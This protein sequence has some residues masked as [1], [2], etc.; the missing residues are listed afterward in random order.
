MVA[1]GVCDRSCRASRLFS[2]HD[3]QSHNRALHRIAGVGKRSGCLAAARATGTAVPGTA[4]RTSGVIAHRPSN[5]T[6]PFPV[7]RDV[8]HLIADRN[9]ISTPIFGLR[10]LSE[11]LRATQP[12]A[13]RPRNESC[14]ILARLALGLPS[15]PRLPEPAGWRRWHPAGGIVHGSSGSGRGNR[16]RWGAPGPA[17]NA[18]RA[19]STRRR[20]SHW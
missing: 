6:R 1:A 5:T 3:R 12:V 9:A 17:R 15:L 18:S 8:R 13:R 20:Y 7:N 16:C 10:G 2:A 4:W 11:C 14:A 19:S